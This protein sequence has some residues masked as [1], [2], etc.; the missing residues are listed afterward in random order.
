MKINM[1]KYLKIELIVKLT[2]A[3]VKLM[4]HNGFMNTLCQMLEYISYVAYN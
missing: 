4:K 1:E 3:K 2:L